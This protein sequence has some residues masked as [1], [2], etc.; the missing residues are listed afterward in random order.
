AL[1]VDDLADVGRVALAAGVEHLLP[2]G[3]ELVADR[4]DVLGGEVRDRVGGLLGDDGQG[5]L[6]DQGM[7]SSQAPAA[8]EMQVWMGTP[9]GPV[10]PGTAV[11]RAPLRRSRTAPERRGTTQPKH[12][13]IRHPLGIRTPASSPASSRER[14]PSV[15]TVVSAPPAENRTVPP[16]PGTI[17]VGRNCSVLSGSPAAAWWSVSASSSPP[18]PQARVV[19]S[20]R[21]GTRS[22]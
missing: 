2:D 13:P 1:H 4:L 14:A 22:D 10:S 17:V 7:A 11:V 3:V 9:S 8:A 16:S 18:G 15:S 19:R 12:T 20:A 6:L 5:E 21:S